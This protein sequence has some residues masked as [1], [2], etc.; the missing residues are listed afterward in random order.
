MHHGS[1]GA[2]GTNR[3][4]DDRQPWHHPRGLE[5]KR[6]EGR[7]PRARLRA[8]AW[9][10][11]IERRVWERSV[12]AAWCRSAA[13]PCVTTGSHL[14][15][16]PH[17]GNYD[18]LAGVAAGLAVL[19]AANADPRRSRS[20]AFG[21]SPCGARRAR[22]S[23]RLILAVGS[24]SDCRHWTRS[25][26][27]SG[28]TAGNRCVIT[29]TTS[30]TREPDGAVAPLLSSVSSRPFSSSISSRDLSWKR[31]ASRLASPRRCAAMSAFPM[32]V[33]EAPMAI[34]PRCRDVSGRTPSL[35]WRNWRSVSTGHW[36]DRIVQG[37]EDFVFTVGKFSTGCGTARHDK[38]GRRREV[39]PQ[40]RRGREDL[41]DTARTLLFDL[42]KGIES[43]RESPSS[44]AARS[45]RYRLQMD[46]M[47]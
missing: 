4:G 40:Y 42:I 46:P 10:A 12:S 1:L 27:L 39:Q 41:L 36:K 33:A 21:L 31:T 11:G 9:P 47:R 22:G 38:G 25:A 15:S 2:P 26:I 23:A 16:V 24:C 13:T 37:D 14:D 30:T 43:D 20:C 28:P 45:G 5:Q 17:G 29:S 3:T 19:A 34:R 6:R 32:R 44:W 18:G 8:A 7:G 35:P